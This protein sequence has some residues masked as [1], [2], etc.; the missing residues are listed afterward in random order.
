MANRYLKV[1]LKS[2]VKITPFENHIEILHISGFVRIVNTKLV[3]V[4]YYRKTGKKKKMEY[5]DINFEFQNNYQDVELSL[6]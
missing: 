4:L 2:V 6:F 3:Q 5:V 1:N